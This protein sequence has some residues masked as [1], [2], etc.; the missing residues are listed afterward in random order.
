MEDSAFLQA[1]RKF[2]KKYG[3]HATYARG[4]SGG[5]GSLWNP[6]KFSLISESLNTHWILL[7][8][9]HLESKEIISLVNVYAPNNAGEKKLCWDSIKNLAD[10]EDLENIVITGDFN[11][12]LLSSE[13]RGGSIVR[14]PA[15]ETVEDLMQ[16]RDLI[17]IKPTTGK[18]T[19][20]NK[21]AGPGHIAAR[22][23]RFLVQSSFL[24]LG[25][26]A[27]S[28]ILHSNTSDHKPISLE[29]LTTKDLGP[30]P[31]RFSSLWIK[32]VNFMDKPRKG[33]KSQLDL[34]SQHL[35]LETAEIS[36][37]DLEKEAKLQQN[38]HKACLAEEKYWRLKSRS[39]WLKVGD[40]NSSF[41]HKQA[42]AR[43]GWNYIIEIKEE[44]NVLKDFASIKKA[45]S[46]HFEKLYKEDIGADQND[47]LLDVVPKLITPKMNQVLESK[48]TLKETKEALYAMD[49]DKAP[50][51]DGFTPR[52]LQ[53][54]WHIIE[55]ELLKMIQK[56]QNCQK[57]GGCTNSTFLALIPKE[58]GA[59]S[60]SKFRPIS[61][62]NIGYKVITKVIANRLKIFLPKIIP[63]N[64]GGF[65]KRMQLVDNFVLVQEAIHSNQHRKEKGGVKH[66]NHALFADDTFLLGAAT[67][68]S[69]TN[70]KSVLDDFCKSLGNELNKGKCQIFCWNIPT[71]TANS[72]AR[73]LGFAASTIW[74]S[75]KYLGLPIF[76]KRASS[77]DWSPL[78]DKFKAEMQAWG[79]SWLNIAGKEVLIKA[80][81]N[82]LPIFKFN[83]LLAP[84]GIINKMEELIRHFFL[85][86]RQA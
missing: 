50:G 20:S 34:E 48:I 11:L 77:K 30:I 51:P 49:P 23:D 74:S 26:E 84:V 73:C 33:K 35:L 46:K 69:A 27:K 39:I 71:S 16:D 67:P 22:L 14:D 38:F 85:E 12:T 63:D 41:F 55:K 36:K 42:Q 45:A 75:F 1:S 72:I 59:N 82:S 9:Q 66:I 81:L 86:R 37:E 58:K 28:H 60:F 56:S 32:E 70:F 80:V 83:V 17:D 13:K 29:L 5:L 61:L 64:Q 78:L 18:Y 19:W 76:N 7:K 52:F 25:L 68:K 57:I 6:N 10:L 21:R 44:N 43:K 8:L 79:S 47:S 3:V 2:W 53:T 65:I 40:R 15:R 31:F 54:C 24:L 4:A 62:C